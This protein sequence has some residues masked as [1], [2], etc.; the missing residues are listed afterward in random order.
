MTREQR[1]KESIEE[2]KEVIEVK[3][4]YYRDSE[5]DKEGKFHTLYK[6]WTRLISGFP[7]EGYYS[8]KDP[9]Y[10]EAVNNLET[11]IKA[12]VDFSKNKFDLTF[13][14]LVEGKDSVPSF[15]FLTSL[16]ANLTVL[17]SIIEIQSQ[18]FREDTTIDEKRSMVKRI[19]N[20]RFGNEAMYEV[21]F[22]AFNYYLKKTCGKGSWE[23]S[24][25]EFQD[26]MIIMGSKTCSSDG[27]K[28]LFEPLL[29]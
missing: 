7:P 19:V 23:V 3:L 15:F 27:M 11:A 21:I 1:I 9:D 2:F 26:A 14:D 8:G 28:V 29:R 16:I 5:D 25:K 10:I 24:E 12:A 13:K 17:Y 6:G 4:K 20:N 22:P 18:L